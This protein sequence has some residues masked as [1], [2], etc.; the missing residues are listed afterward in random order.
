LL[1]LLLSNAKTARSAGRRIAIG[2]LAIG[3]LVTIVVDPVVAGGLRAEA[4]RA[5]AP[6][7]TRLPVTVGVVAVE[8]LVP[9][10]V[11]PVVARGL[12][13]G[14]DR[15][16]AANAARASIA[17][18][19]EA[20][21]LAVAIVVD[22]VFAGRLDA[23]AIG[24][25]AAVAAARRVA[26]LVGAVDVSVVVVVDAIGTENFERSPEG[27]HAPRAAGLRV[28]VVVLAI[29]QAVAVAILPITAHGLDA[30]TVG[31]T[32]A[33]RTTRHVATIHV[34]TIHELVSVVIEAVRA[35][36]LV[37]STKAR[38]TAV[39]RSAV[40]VAAVPRAVSVVVAR[41][42]AIGFS[43]G[44]SVANAAGSTGLA[45][46]FGARAIG[47][48]TAHVG[49]RLPS[50][51]RT[52]EEVEAIAS[53]SGRARPTVELAARARDARRVGGASR[54]A[55]DGAARA[56]LGNRRIDMRVTIGAAR[57]TASHR[58]REHNQR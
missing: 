10:I 40:L 55:S 28:A 58:E 12:L 29:D 38:A 47:D 32:E 24:A 44:A 4:R 39:Q 8:L 2:V 45:R 35:A 17:V 22:V 46:A 19:V 42:S 15:A 13:A 50:A 49:F 37:A 41:V 57:R 14:P 9:V 26:V 27:A 25:L 7:S 33:A 36:R 53:A 6:G 48:P 30:A 5:H 34:V 3:E 51:A 11:D 43:C 54:G 1:E 52:R 56:C 18:P 23:H 20:I 31:G 21:G 16:S